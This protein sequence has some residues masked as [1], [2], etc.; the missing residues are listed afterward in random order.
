M[1]RLIVPMIAIVAL[2]ACQTT[3]EQDQRKADAGPAVEFHPAHYEAR[4]N[5]E[6]GSYSDLYTS[7]SHALW[8]SREVAAV[9]WQQA[10]DAGDEPDAELQSDAVS[11][12]DGYILIECS[13][14]SVFGDMSVAYDAV[15][16]RGVA[17]YLEMP[18]GNR[19]TPLQRVFHGTL[20]EEPHGA[21]KRFRRTVFLAF[22]KRDLWMQ[23][24]VFEKEMQSVKLTLESV[25]G[26]FAYSWTA[27]PIDTIPPVT[28]AERKAAAIVGFEQLYEKM[29]TL[30]RITQ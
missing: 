3:P 14:E 17:I 20:Q 7:E 18:N 2:A 16:L 28:G 24:P 27:A 13:L 29:R 21:L 4:L 12:S 15:G 25:H 19:V 23:R 6:G 8:V 22:P 11:I 1:K 9:K 5:F 30:A 26:K 10:V